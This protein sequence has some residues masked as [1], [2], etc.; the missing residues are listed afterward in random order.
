MFHSL[1]VHVAFWLYIEDKIT[2]VKNA[3]IK[4]HFR[5]AFQSLQNVAT[6]LPDWRNDVI[7]GK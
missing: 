1:L 4:C 3:F 2:R 6:D 5:L 7:N